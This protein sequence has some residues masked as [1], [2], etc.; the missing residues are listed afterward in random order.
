VVYEKPKLEVCLNNETIEYYTFSSKD[1]P[2]KVIQK[3]YEYYSELIR[4]LHTKFQVLEKRKILLQEQFE[5]L[6]IIENKRLKQ[7]K[8]RIKKADDLYEKEKYDWITKNGSKHLQLLYNLNYND[9][10]E[11]SYIEERV[12]QEF[13]GWII[14]YD[15]KVT[16]NY[17]SNPSTKAIKN[18]MIVKNKGLNADIVW[19]KEGFKDI[20]SESEAVV[21]YDYLNQY[22]LYKKVD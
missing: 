18:Q 4:N 9:E 10:C 1:S 16:F 20:S 14:D 8:S 5:A 21:V 2:N 19:I 11:K 7:L 15:Q 13:E 3:A 17:R 22:R 6:N 12:K